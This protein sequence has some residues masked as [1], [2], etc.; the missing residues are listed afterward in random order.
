MPSRTTIIQCCIG[1]LSNWARK[2][3]KR[4]PK[5]KEATV[6]LFADDIICKENPNNSPENC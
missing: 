1:S 5:Q 2:R 3:N 6:S 4:H